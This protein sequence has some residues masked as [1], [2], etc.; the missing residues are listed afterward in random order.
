M[1]AMKPFVLPALCILLLSSSPAAAVATPPLP[2]D[3]ALEAFP[4]S[5]TLRAA[6]YDGFLS[7]PREA[8]L[9]RNA[10]VL[11]NEWGNFRLSS[12]RSG[13]AFYVILAPAR[14]KDFP[15]YAQGSWIIKRS[16][17]DGRFIQAKVFLR[18]DPGCFVRIY[19][20]GERSLMDVVLYGAVLNKELPLPVS[21]DRL[22]GLPFSDIV[23]WSGA[24]VDWSLFSP[25]G[26]DYEGIT[27]L[28]TEIR[29]RLPSLRYLDDGGLDASASLVFIE[30]GKPQG[31]YWGL[32]C[33]GFAQWFIDGLVAP[34]GGRPLDYAMLKEKHPE[35]RA[36]SVDQAIDDRHDPFFGLDWT[37]NLGQAWA[38]ITSP[39]RSH[40]YTE[41]DVRLSPFALFSPSSDA[42]NGGSSY[43]AF[44][45]YDVDTGTPIRGLKALLYILAVKDP[46]EIYLAS[47]SRADRTGL[48]RHYHVAVLLPWFDEGGT[49]RV[50][51]FE[52]AAETNL[53]AV[54][55]RAKTD[56]V[57]LVR[58][59]PGRDFDP[60][61]LP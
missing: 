8:V 20:A 44:P 11:S 59:H 14:G 61:V 22:L 12:V 49:F 2:G 42:V 37:R 43:E 36:A 33:S 41:N 54:M 13:D 9:A 34:L 39:A 31:R 10:R 16:L 1:K 58:I 6:L 3:A 7:A 27:W 19:P 48:R 35:L 38:S 50:N 28:S 47:F 25:R 21:F 60:P 26:G 57:H 5:A 4:D 56:S 29:K 23:S 17:D 24:W 18:S 45:Q 53:D 15:L 51:V 32:N 52:S 55:S 40:S 30:S 46:G